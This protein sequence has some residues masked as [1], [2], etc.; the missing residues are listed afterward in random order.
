MHKK[1]SD[2]AIFDEKIILYEKK[3]DF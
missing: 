3:T 2:P 1:E